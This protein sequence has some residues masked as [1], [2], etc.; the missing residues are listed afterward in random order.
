M[1]ALALLEAGRRRLSGPERWTTR[2][3][4]RNAKGREVSRCSQEAC[5]WCVAGALGPSDGDPYFEA[6]EALVDALPAGPWG[7][8]PAQFNDATGTTFADV[9]ALYDRA[10]AKLRGTL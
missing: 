1:T 2:T 10:I 3:F 8:E 5:A 9:A 4:A 7:R 6:L